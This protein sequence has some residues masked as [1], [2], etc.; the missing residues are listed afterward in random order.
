MTGSE[1]I[2]DNDFSE[3]HEWEVDKAGVHRLRHS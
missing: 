3:K 2:R 1:E